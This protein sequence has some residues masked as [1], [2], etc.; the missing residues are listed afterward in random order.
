MKKKP[1]NRITLTKQ[2]CCK[3]NKTKNWLGQNLHELSHYVKCFLA[4]T[5]LL[6]SEIVQ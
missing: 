3:Q 2:F 4:S 6:N 5:S 1:H